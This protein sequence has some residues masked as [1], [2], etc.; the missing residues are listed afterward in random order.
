MIEVYN[1]YNTFLDIILTGKPGE[2][3][4]TNTYFKMVDTNSIVRVNIINCEK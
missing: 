2:W 3:I 4:F 1:K